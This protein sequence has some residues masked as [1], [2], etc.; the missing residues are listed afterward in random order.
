MHVKDI[1]VFLSDQHSPLFSEYAGGPARTPTLN[2]LCAEGTSYTSCYTSC[3]LCVPARMSML[4]GR[5]PSKTGVMRNN[6]TIPDVM[7][8]FLHPFV[9]AGYETVLIGRMHFVGKDQRHG[10]TKRLAQDMTPVTWNRP[11]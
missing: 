7:P 1:L 3:P 4:T 6:D 2:R 8:T 11:V 10:F 5:L 9:A